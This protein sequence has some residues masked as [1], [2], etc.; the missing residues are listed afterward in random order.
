MDFMC[1]L[2]PFSEI[3]SHIVKI[4]TLIWLE[5]SEIASQLALQMHEAK[6]GIS[7]G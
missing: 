4:M 3:W 1:D 2:E 7:V 5:S 6:V